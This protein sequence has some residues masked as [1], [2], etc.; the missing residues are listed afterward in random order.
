M[1]LA[2]LS[3]ENLHSG[4]LIERRASRIV[5][6]VAALTVAAVLSSA[7]AAS[8]AATVFTWGNV[9]SDWGAGGN[10]TP[11]GPPTGGT[12]VAQFTSA[13]YS[14]QPTLVSASQTVGGIWDTGAGAVT[15]GASS[16]FALTLTGTTV[17]GHTTTGVEVDAG[18][19]A[20]T[21]NCPVTLSATQVW[22]N[23]SANPLTV[24]NTVNC[25]SQ[26]ITLNMTGSGSLVLA[27]SIGNMS[28]TLNNIFANVTISGTVSAG[29]VL[30][31]GDA[32]APLTSATTSIAPGGLINLLS[33]NSNLPI[34][35]NLVVNGGTVQNVS[36]TTS[37]T[38]GIGWSSGQAGVL[39][40]NSGLVN[41]AGVT[42]NFGHA[43]AG[44]LN[45]NGGTYVISTEPTAGSGTLNFNGGMLQLN[46]SIATFVPTALALDVGNGGANFNVQGFGTNINVPLTATGSGG[47]SVFGTSAGTLGLSANN[48]YTGPTTINGGLVAIAGAGNLGAGNVLTLN[49]GRI[50]LGGTTPVV[51]AVNITA[52]AAN[53]NTIQ[54]GTLNG[55][56]YNA[57][58]TS[59]NAVVAANLSGTGGLTM[60]G[61]S[62]QLT[63][64]VPSQ[65]SGATNVTGGTLTLNAVGSNSGALPSTSAV[66]VGPGATLAAQGGAS[67]G[68][69]LTLAAGANLNLSDGS[70]TTFF[71]VN[72]GLNTN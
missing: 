49:G 50:D 39:T 29:K 48:T 43:R 3:V 27:G 54:N 18:A 35:S 14:F 21:I 56:S 61:A 10:W 20:L 15:I 30:F 24:G 42:V 17:N 58:N 23:N 52:A 59:G 38:V 28:N 51:T 69:G 44:T 70:A 37:D 26:G 41:F 33:G 67:I 65:F 19:G 68:S 1:S 31:L 45:L 62:G 47:L 63:L 6:V 11:V 53:G 46:G 2:R 72:G 34:S 8:A 7:S 40:I 5:R 60:S 16:N 12:A 36:A 25:G 64:T 4:G 55:T 57:S 66:T 71:T 22:I 13:S 9:G 32:S